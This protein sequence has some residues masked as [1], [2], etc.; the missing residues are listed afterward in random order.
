MNEVANMN[1]D[2][3]P[4]QQAICSQIRTLGRDERG[5]ILILTAL[6]FPV[7]L[8]FLGL[9]LDMGTIYH[10]KRRQQKAADAAAFGAGQELWRGRNDVDFLALAART[11]AS[12]NGFTHYSLDGG[13]PDVDVQVNYPYNFAIDLG[14]G[15][16]EFVEVVIT[17]VKVPTYFLRI[18]GQEMATVQSRAVAGLKKGYGSGCVI[19]LDPDDR[20]ALKVSG[21]GD[22][23]TNCGIMVNSTDPNAIDTTAGACLISDEWIGTSGYAGIGGPC[24]APDVQETALAVADPLEGLPAPPIPATPYA[25]GVRINAADCNDETQNPQF[26]GTWPPF[27]C[28]ADGVYHWPTGRYDNLFQMQGGTHVFEPGIYILN[29][30]L[31]ITGNNT[32]IDGM[33]VG[34]YN[35][36]LNTGSLWKAIDIGAGVEGT[37]SAPLD[38]PMKGILFWVDHDQPLIPAGNHIIGH[39]TMV[40]SGTIYM[41]SQHLDY[42]GSNSTNGEWTY[43]IA[44]TIDVHGGATVTDIKYLHGPDP[45]TPGTPDVFQVTLLE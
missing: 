16:T 26:V 1:N 8:A 38:G 21:K 7:L 11:D 42:G 33:G 30:G 12:M 34:F 24:V 39:S 3:W 35:T 2:K 13:D 41:A 22:L 45:D 20:D 10:L 4:R 6:I 43:I 32:V 28:D 15:E 27:T 36:D 23:R 40:I 31:K 18:V 25:S 44:S 19:A 29:S 17:E 37:L 9:A 14:N 5:I